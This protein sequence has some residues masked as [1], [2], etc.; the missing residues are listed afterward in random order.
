M[1]LVIVESPSKAKT[2]EKYLGKD[3]VVDASGGHVRDLPE[4]N[5]G[6]DVRRNFQPRY[7]VSESKKATIKRLSDR[8]KRA[9]R[10]YLAT[11]PDREGEAISWHLAEV[12]GLDPAEENR[13]VFNEISQKAV[14]EALENPR[15]IAMGLV[16]AQQAR[17]VL[18]RLVGY[19][20]S[21]FLCKHLQDKLSAGRVQSVALRMIVEREQEIIKFKPKEY[22]NIT[23]LLRLAQGSAEDKDIDFKALLLSYQGKKKKPES[24][25]QA[26]DVLAH[27]KGKDWAVTAVKKAVSKSR[28]SAPF[29]TSTLQQDGSQ[30]L[31]L[32]SPQ[33]M[34]TAQ[35]LYEGVPLGGEG[36]VALVTYI[37]TDSVRVSADAQ[38]E[39]R[40][41]IRSSYGDKYLPSK[42]NFYKS[43]KQAQDAHEAIRPIS[44]SRT[45]ESVRALLSRNHYRLYKLIYERFLASQMTDATFNTVTADIAAGDAVFRAT[46]KTLLF[47]GYTA[48][49]EDYKEKDDS[50]GE[51]SSA[52]LPALS[53]GD[54]LN[55]KDLK[56]EQKFTKPP[57]RYTDATLVKMMEEK[58]IG[59]PSTYASIIGVLMK[60]TYTVKEGRFL[61]PTELAFRVNET[62]IKFFDNIVDVSFTARM[63]DNLDEIE[64]G[65]KDWRKL[66][67]D[68]YPWLQKRLEQAGESLIEHTDIPCDKCG[69]GHMLIRAGRY[70]KFM[71][72]SNYPECKA[73]R[74]LD[75]D[76]TDQVCEKC[77][78]AM[79]IKQGKF[80]KYLACTGYPDC[81]N[82]RPLESKP[83]KVSDV[84]CPTCQKLMVERDG[85]FGK[86]HRCADCNLNRPIV[87]KAGICPLCGKD[88][89][90]KRSKA[91]K[92]FYGCSG[93]PGCTFVSWDALSSEKCPDCGAHMTQ[94]P[95]K[96]GTFIK[97][98]SCTYK[99]TDKADNSGDTQAQ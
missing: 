86:Y 50:D 35:Q 6:V 23:A 38:A 82:I 87:E 41:F 18:D 65:G 19:K 73:T 59:R 93:Y 57:A 17:R 9:D 76:I 48:V 47:K 5:L 63:E 36:Q 39:A 2:I 22:W 12:L 30:K 25:E 84:P 55:L 70:G 68:F 28:P 79:A 32:T 60:R 13:I 75:D 51:D 10:V 33:V 3:F 11:D 78:S 61:K 96:D 26:D 62:L 37:R 8:A 4:K 42:P 92:I 31:G 89:H 90:K 14:K 52:R 54:A 27:V 53:E 7:E 81:S 58:G 98:S 91:G 34:Q 49:Y 15:P 44:L 46:G 1:N 95:V 66:V 74:P 16:D 88:V 71:A 94:K 85:K 43:K 67:G 99:R 72:C 45:P 97:C 29:T 77:G 64:E 69:D 20:L 80:G 21:P 83:D 56:S 40:E 24:K